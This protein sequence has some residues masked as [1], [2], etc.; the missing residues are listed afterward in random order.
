MQVRY[1]AALRPEGSDYNRSRDQPRFD[2]CY[3]ARL[4]GVF[5]RGLR[6]TP[7]AALAASLWLAACAAS[8]AE[9][10]REP[11]ETEH[12]PSL[13]TN[14]SLAREARPI[15]STASLA[16]DALLIEG[17]R[18][19]RPGTA[20]P[21]PTYAPSW[22]ARP[23]VAATMALAHRP[24]HREIVKAA[25]RAGID[26]VLVHAV[27]RVE[28]AYN[29]RAVSPRGAVGLMQ[30]M[31]GTARRFGVDD[32]LKPGASISAGTQYLSHL[33]RIFE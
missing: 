21:E 1:Q 9:N 28:S 24:F 8:A 29:A 32:L 25:E 30:V 13:P 14:A 7:A 15:E 10:A 23:N 18:R 11:G 5:M 31:P 27:I 19:Q 33:M 3:D 20:P 16:R 17:W 22:A 26:P 6:S 12:R 2:G 4:K